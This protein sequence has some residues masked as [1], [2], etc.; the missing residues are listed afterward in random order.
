MNP[1]EILQTL[2]PKELAIGSGVTFPIEITKKTRRVWD[3]TS[4]SYVEKELKGW[5]PKLGDLDLII[6]N[7]Q[8]AFLYPLGFRI[9]E[10]DY[11]NNLEACIEEPNTQALNFFIKDEIQSLLARYENR[12]SYISTQMK[13]LPEGMAIR[14]HYRLNTEVPIEDYLDLFVPSNS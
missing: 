9:R 13:N 3:D 5:Y 14:I 11:G 1:L 7:L 6:N 4:H 2:T 8:S 12:I 10:E